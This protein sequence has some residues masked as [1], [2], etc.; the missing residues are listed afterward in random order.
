[1][2]DYSVLIPP[3]HIDFD[4]GELHFQTPVGVQRYPMPAG[5]RDV[6][7]P[8]RR[9]DIDVERDRLAITLRDGTVA[10]VELGVISER[11]GDDRRGRLVAYLDQNRWSTLS[12]WRHGNRVIS[13]SEADGARRIAE[14]VRAG[15]LI[16]P[17]SAAH[18]IETSALH[19]ER[20]TTLAATML[21]FSRGWQSRNPV[22]VRREELV[23]ALR[24]EEPRARSIVS[25]GPEGIFTQPLRQPSGDARWPQVMAL[26]FPR[27]VN[28]MSVYSTLISP[29]K[30]PNETGKAA[31]ERWS[32]TFPRLADW[33]RANN[34]TARQ[35]RMTA[36]GAVLADLAPEIEQLASVP[37]IRTWLE[38]SYGDV[39]ALPYLSRY[40]AVV[41]AR[42]RNAGRWEGNDLIDL[43]Y[44]CSAAAYADLVVGERRT[45]GE[46]RTAS[47]IPTGATLA[48]NLAE[49]ASLLDRR[50]ATMDPA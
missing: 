22:A 47:G 44:L 50:F 25:L 42:I 27:L 2:L 15:K 39:T 30:V 10:I 40:R 12:A 11:D 8:L 17:M 43:H 28:V 1:M 24:G 5:F 41:F 7:M 48:T 32:T 9:M 4:T 16:L 6:N 31:A 46:L 38:R 14:Y 37:E 23:A 21:E 34:A 3:G 18:M 20:R 29:Q 36:H 19:S 35:A 26:A 45:I 49:A 13:P 33:L